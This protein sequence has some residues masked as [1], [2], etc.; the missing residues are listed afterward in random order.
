M[1]DKGYTCLSIASVGIN[2]TQH[3]IYTCNL[4][5]VVTAAENLIK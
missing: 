1:R 2:T 3:A 4:Q 5:L